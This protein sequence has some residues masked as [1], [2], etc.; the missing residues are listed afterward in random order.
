[1]K[2]LTGIPFSEL[3]A[4]IT[5]KEAARVLRL[6]MTKLYRLINEG[7]I[8]HTRHGNGGGKRILVSVAG[9]KAAM[10]KSTGF[11]PELDTAILEAINSPDVKRRRGRPSKTETHE[12]LVITGLS[13]SNRTGFGDAVVL[14][15][16]TEGTQHSTEISIQDN[17][18]IEYAKIFRLF[19]SSAIEL[20]TFK[21]ETIAKAIDALEAPK[22]E[23]R[24]TPTDSGLPIRKSF[25]HLRAVYKKLGR[26][27]NLLYGKLPAEIRLALKDPAEIK[28]SLSSNLIYREDLRRHKDRMIVSKPRQNET[29]CDKIINKLLEV[30]FFGQGRDF[31]SVL[32][33]V[34]K[35]ELSCSDKSTRRALKKAIVGGQLSALGYGKGTKYILGSRKTIAHEQPGARPKYPR[36]P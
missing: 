2:A 5:T 8:S 13:T 28:N 19:L 4:F 10:E 6:G 31:G 20:Q 3:P 12:R 36:N 18:M 23:N 21:D 15:R 29:P 25:A 34:L 30:G 22:G 35:T 16:N 9:L 11:D 17:L 27:V 14:G 24:S 33:E 1:M 26:K 32:A 7:H